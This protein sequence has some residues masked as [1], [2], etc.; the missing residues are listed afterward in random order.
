VFSFCV[1]VRVHEWGS[2]QV[3]V[4]WWKHKACAMKQGDRSVRR[5]ACVGD[6]GGGVGSDPAHKR[7]GLLHAKIGR[8]RKK[9]HSTY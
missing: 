5:Q 8:E 3:S 9:G 6:R 2:K 4:G 1:S 7:P